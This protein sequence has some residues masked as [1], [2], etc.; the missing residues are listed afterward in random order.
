MKR[1]KEEIEELKE[2]IGEDSPEALFADGLDEAILG[3]ARVFG[4]EAVV[5]YDYE[6]C[7]EVFMAGGMTFDEAEEWMSFNVMGAYVGEM[8][9]IFV[10]TFRDVEVP[11]VLPPEPV[12]TCGAKEKE[13]G[14]PCTAKHKRGCVWL[15]A[16]PSLF[17][18]HGGARPGE[19]SDSEAN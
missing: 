1:S 17:T 19:R 18:N 7:V 4:K 13:P 2:Q 6:A 16:Q 15:D 5:A 9:P 3:L 11:A 8:T 12:C 10:R 14:H